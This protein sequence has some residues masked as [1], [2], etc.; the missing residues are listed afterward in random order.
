MTQRAEP[1][2]RFP[3]VVAWISLGLALALFFG[4]TVGAV[5][6]RGQLRAAEQELKDLQ[7][8]YDAYILEARARTPGSH[9]AREDDLQALLVAIDRLD[10]VPAELLQ[11]YP[12]Q[13]APDANAKPAAPKVTDR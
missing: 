7:E 11:R 10:L 12:E 2:S 9:P 5:R 4:N 13:P 8:S 6:E 1:A 3:Q